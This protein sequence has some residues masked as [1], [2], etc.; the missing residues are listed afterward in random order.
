MGHNC[1]SEIVILVNIVLLKLQV[2]GE[3]S[4]N[5]DFGFQFEPPGFR[6]YNIL[7]SY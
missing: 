7:S 1:G 4:V 5:H 6:E 3:S 2:F